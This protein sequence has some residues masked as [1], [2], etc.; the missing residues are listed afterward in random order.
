MVLLD[1]NVVSELMRAQPEPAVLRWVDAQPSPD[2]HMSAITLAELLHGIARLPDGRRRRAL[3]EQLETMIDVDMDHRVVAFDEIAAAHYADIV[4]GRE[5][6][7]RPIG[8][9]DAQ[10]AATCRSHGAVLATRNTSDFADT[11]VEVVDPWTAE[12]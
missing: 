2:L 4:A 5:S 9:A 7:G 8:M 10:I 3:A 11:S 6:S 12:P 1:T